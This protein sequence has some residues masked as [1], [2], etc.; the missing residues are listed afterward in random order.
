MIFRK[1]FFAK[2]LFVGKI[3]LTLPSCSAI[4]WRF[5]CVDW[6]QFTLQNPRRVKTTQVLSFAPFYLPKSKVNF[7]QLL[8]LQLYGHD[9]ALLCRN[10]ISNVFSFRS[11]AFKLKTTNFLATCKTGFPT[12]RRDNYV[13]GTR[14]IPQ[15]FTVVF[16][17]RRCFHWL[18]S[19]IYS[20]VNLWPIITSKDTRT[21]ALF[22]I[23]LVNRYQKNVRNEKRLQWHFIVK[24]WT[25]GL[26][27]DTEKWN[28]PA[29]PRAALLLSYSDVLFVFM[30]PSWMLLKTYLG[31]WKIFPTAPA[32]KLKISPIYFEIL[33]SDQ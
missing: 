20:R 26:T 3:F 10:I 4:F 24:H 12:K 1:R 27:A 6:E 8:F 28:S 32:T 25:K 11:T 29:F 22:R 9:R 19:S 2:K 18:A 13:T 5:V 16:Q 17:I 7:F 14:S 31:L 15:K 23:G 33:S 21:T 30:L